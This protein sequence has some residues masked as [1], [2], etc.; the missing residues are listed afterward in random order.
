[1]DAL[2]EAL[3]SVHMTGAIFYRAE[4]RRPWG[5]AVPALETYAPILAPGTERL[6]SYHLVT[7]GPALVRFAG[8]EVSLAPGDLLIMPHGNP[9]LLSNGHPRQIVQAG[10]SLDHSLA[11][12]ISML[13]IGGEGEMTRLICG[14]F[15]C[16]RRADRLF[17]G[18]LPDFIRIPVRDDP[19]GAWIE[20]SIR[21][22]VGL[23]G[24]DDPGR[25]ILLSKMAEALFIEALRR[26]MAGLP[27]EQTGWLAAARDPV[28]G[29]AI[30]AMHA[31]P[32][33][34]WTLDGLARLAASSRSV[35][36]DRFARYLGVAPLAYLATWRM[37]LASQ[38]LLTSC[39]SIL[40]IGLGIGYESEASFIRAF[41]REF[42][43]PPAKYRKIMAA[44]APGPASLS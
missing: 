22:L 16:D 34:R 20:S 26:Y 4:C 28:V 1:M 14:Y 13:Q 2:S 3:K 25:S 12:Q 43:Q 8:A 32:A 42:G 10:I 37:Q 36:I 21:H 31:D 29:M 7:E 41:K 44:L 24:A 9:H 40:Q 15:G 35:L 17:L 18:G 30:A 27:A 33:R 11:G 38:R 5:F 19:A 6:V 39:E 23:A